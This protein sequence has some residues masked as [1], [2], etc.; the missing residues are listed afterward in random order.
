LSASPKDSD[1][2]EVPL[3]TF[4]EVVV[5]ALVSAAPDFSSFLFED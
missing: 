2:E 5:V 1:D 3:M 4:V